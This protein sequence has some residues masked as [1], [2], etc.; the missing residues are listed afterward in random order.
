MGTAGALAYGGS[1]S[2]GNGWDGGSATA[3]HTATVGTFAGAYSEG[4]DGD[5]GPGPGPGPNPNPSPN[6][7]LARLFGGGGSSS[8]INC[9]NYKPKTWKQQK[10]WKYHCEFR[11]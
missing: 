7:F 3:T 10:Q 6:G 9:A 4:P 5:P 1:T 2:T 11:K 8:D